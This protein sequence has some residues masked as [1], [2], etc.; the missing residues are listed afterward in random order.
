M[1]RLEALSRKLRLTRGS[2]ALRVYHEIGR[3]AGTLLGPKPPTGRRATGKVHE[4]AAQ[5]GWGEGNTYKAIR[6]AGEFDQQTLARLV[7]ARTA[8]GK[9]LFSWRSIVQLLRI[10]DWR[11]R[12]GL[13]E[14]VIR[15]QLNSDQ[16][17]RVINE[18][19]GRPPS[20]GATRVRD[21]EHAFDLYRRQLETCRDRAG[22][23]RRAWSCW[24][25]PP[26]P[27]PQGRRP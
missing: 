16:L 24:P 20:G 22:L 7:E 2:P 9:D 14:R 5:L 1:T 27:T 19:V 23:S 21:A 12:R 15:E 13:M 3:L 18:Q 8:N 26:R 10:A 17:S 6:F 4:L 25:P 11:T